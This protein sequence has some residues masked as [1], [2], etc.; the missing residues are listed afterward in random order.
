MVWGLQ[1]FRLEIYGKPI[2]LLS[3]HQALEPQKKQIKKT[4]SAKLT[5][6]LD[7]LAQFEKSIKH[8]T[9]C[10]SN[11]KHLLSRNPIAKPEPIENYDEELVINCVIALL[12][13]IINTHDS[14]TDEEKST[15]QTD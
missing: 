11:L 5:R 1:H 2:E 3:D 15:S 8:N 6:W 13:F 7:S 4:Y 9:G 12:E 14:I 10:H